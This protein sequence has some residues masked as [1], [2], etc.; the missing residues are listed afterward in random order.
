VARVSPDSIVDESSRRFQIASLRNS[1][2]DARDGAC[3]ISAIAGRGYCFVTPVFH[4][5]EPKAASPAISAGVLHAALPNRL[6][7]MVGRQEETRQISDQLMAS[8]LVSIVGA[9]G[10][11]K[12]TVAIAVAHELLETFSGAVTFIDLSSLTDPK[13]S[14]LV[15]R[16]AKCIDGG[17]HGSITAQVFSRVHF[18]F[19][20]G[21]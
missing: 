19:I 17:R 13:P 7:R 20:L 14:L 1:L 16:Q 2:G 10:I 12:T 6:T 8:R 4:S 5:N 15:S 11:G 3:Y 9:G 21:R 18:I